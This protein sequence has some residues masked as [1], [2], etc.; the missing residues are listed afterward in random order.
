MTATSNPLQ[1]VPDEDLLEEIELRMEANP[2]DFTPCPDWCAS[3]SAH[4][5]GFPEHQLMVAED[6]HFCVLI[7]EYGSPDATIMFGDNIKFLTAE[8]TDARIAALS[9]AVRLVRGET[10]AAGR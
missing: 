6:E 4:A 10:E 5:D 3:A 9:E 1:A 8:Q 7:T 2:S